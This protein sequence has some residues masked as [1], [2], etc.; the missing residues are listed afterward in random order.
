MSPLW[1]GPSA[2]VPAN[3]RRLSGEGD[4]EVTPVHRV[5]VPVVPSAS[6][7]P[8]QIDPVGLRLMALQLENEQLR[9]ELEQ[10][11]GEA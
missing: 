1:L 3:V 8:R 11:R 9:A 2:V 6:V 7:V 10:L 5:A 4:P